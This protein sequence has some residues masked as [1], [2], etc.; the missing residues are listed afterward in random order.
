MDPIIIQHA[1]Q[2]GAKL[3][4]DI[5]VLLGQEVELKAR[6][7]L[8]EIH[9]NEQNI[10]VVP[11]ELNDAVKHFPAD[12]AYIKGVHPGANKVFIELIKETSR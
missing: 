6:N 10:S 1:L 5:K 12:R 7:N 3:M 9:N 4:D 2:F 11:G 8:I